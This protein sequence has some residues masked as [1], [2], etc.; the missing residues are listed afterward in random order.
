MRGRALIVCNNPLVHREKTVDLSAT[1]LGT[2]VFAST[3]HKQ[4]AIITH[5]TIATT[6]ETGSVLDK[7]GLQP[8]RPA[9]KRSCTTH[10]LPTYKAKQL[11]PLSLQ[12]YICNHST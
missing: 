12:L 2:I 10:R 11:E 6:L 8:V 5:E 1:L 4:L 7:P 3:F 9:L